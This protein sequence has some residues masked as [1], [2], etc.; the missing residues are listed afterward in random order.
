MKKELSL[1]AKI[2]LPIITITFLAL[3][4]LTYFA[5]TSSFK[6]AR[7]DAEFKISKSAESFA[8]TIKA[9]LDA[10]LMVAQ[11]LEAYLGTLKHQNDKKDR[12]QI[13]EVLKE[14]LIQAPSVFGVWALFEP[15]AFDKMDA[16]YNGQPGYEKSGGFGPYWNRSGKDG[17]LNW[18]NDLNYAGEFYTAPKNAGHRIL[19]EPYRDTVNGQ[20]LLMTSAVAPIYEND[21][22]FAGVVGI[23]LLL[24][25]LDKQ[26][27]TVKPYETSVAYLISDS[28]KY[29]TNP[30]P[31]SVGKPVELAFSNDEFKAALAEN[32]LILKT[33]TDNSGVEV[34]N[35]LV[36]IAMPFSKI[37]WGVLISTP[38]KTVLADAY[39]LLWKQL[40]I[41][42]I[43]LVVMM[44]AVYFISRRIA[45]RFIA[46]TES[47]AKAENI[48]T[49]AIDQLSR[50]GQNLANSSTESAA[51][52]EETVA[53]LEEL[54]SMV[55]KNTKNA[56]EAARL[57]GD[58]NQNAE[59]GNVEMTELVGAMD[60][61]SK[62][63]QKIAEINSVIDDLSFQ[64]NLLALNASVEAARAGEHGKGFAVVADAVR[65]L[66]QKSAS[67][68]KDIN[69]LINDSL[70]KVQ[71]GSHK[72]EV[73][74]S[75]LTNI[76]DSVRKVSHLNGEIST[77]SDEQSIGI[78]QISKAMNSLDQSIQTNA[79][80][81]EEIA[82]NVQEILNQAHVMK[83]VVSE[84][85]AV[86]HGS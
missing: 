85:N 24:S 38:V 50:S 60:E 51:S 25:H 72:A 20:S 73:F 33:G 41:F 63:S 30:D 86:V 15:N 75:N 58:S 47:L 81:A 65:S 62:S 17:E 27:V 8:N 77:A 16:T 44:A 37:S 49:G 68:A 59:R 10:S 1:Q 54:T 22:Q 5:V 13:N 26:I 34:M 39:D 57:S 3:G 69:G 53:S 80:S 70:D 4:L 82:A 84:M 56:R 83:G 31:N 2:T 21:K 79:A 11:Q 66:A 18:V 28:Y 71:K 78:E 9:D 19:T 40:I 43:C 23:D 64:T 29:I 6:T 14:M 61:I 67:A 35:I 45:A 46:L 74:N 52:I 48:V 55:Q 7:A 76:V 42:F 36:P 12:R 32:R